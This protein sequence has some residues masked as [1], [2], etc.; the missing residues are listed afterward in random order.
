MGQSQP[1]ANSSSDPISK[2]PSLTHTQR[3]GGVAQGVG[4]EFKSQY[5]KKKMWRVLECRVGATPSHSVQELRV[6]RDHTAIAGVPGPT[7]W[8]RAQ[9]FSCLLP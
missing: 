5:H 6:R 9:G 8:H 1:R 2:N 3:A 7:W 4:A